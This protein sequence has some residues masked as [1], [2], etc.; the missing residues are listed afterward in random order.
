MGIKYRQIPKK[1]TI[2]SN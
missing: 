1:K 2:V